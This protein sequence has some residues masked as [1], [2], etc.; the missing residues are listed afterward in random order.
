M[1]DNELFTFTQEPSLLFTYVRRTTEVARK[2]IAE[3]CE[4]V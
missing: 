3:V 2:V 1:D 4:A